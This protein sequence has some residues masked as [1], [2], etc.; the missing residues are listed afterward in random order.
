MAPWERTGL[1]SFADRDGDGRMRIAADAGANEVRVDPDVLV[2]AHPEM[3]GFPPWVIGLVAAGAL[4]A[5]LS[6]AA[7]LVLVIASGLAHD[8]VRG[9]FVPRLSERAE[10]WWARLASAGAVAAAA[11]LAVR[12]P[13][14]VAQIVTYAFG[15]AASSFFPA[16]V[17][18]IF[19]RR[20][21]R[22]GAVAGM[23]AG[24]AFTLLYVLRFAVLDPGRAHAGAW[25]LGISPEGIGVVGMLANLAVTV[26]VSLATPPPPEAVQAMVAALRYPREAP[27]R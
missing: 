10:L 12:A 18:G 13:G 22:Q 2:L 17:L 24:T 8:V 15:L 20:A 27:R 16:I 3:A 19:W 11:A 4:A 6:T 1:V 25:W 9:T 5:A 21:T 23:L 26:A 7:G 14:N